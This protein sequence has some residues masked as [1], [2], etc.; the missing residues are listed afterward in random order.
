M[1]K[2]GTVDALDVLLGTTQVQ[3]VYIG[4]DVVWERSTSL[5]PEGYTQLEY[6]ESTADGS[7]YIDLNLQMWNAEPIT[8]EIDM[9]I[10]LI[11]NGSD[12]NN[13][14]VVLGA[15][16]EI[17]PYPGFAIRRQNSGVSQNRNPYAAYGSMGQVITIHQRQ[18]NLSVPSHTRSTTL[19]AGLNSSGQPF[20][21]S[22]ARI[23]YCK[24]KTSG[25]SWLRDLIPCLNPQGKAG[26]YDIVNGVFYTSP[27]GVDFEYGEL[28]EQ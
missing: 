11:G 27:N 25:E 26:L 17:S 15:N 19:F 21:Y 23:Y 1:I 9:K 3:K 18:E 16:E 28:Q 20:R 22:H 10:N 8:Y 7:Q 4:T 12:N 2:L 24:L 6:I 13:Q 5:L 14:C